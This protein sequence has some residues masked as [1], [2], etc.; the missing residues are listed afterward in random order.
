MDYNINGV[1]VAGERV[2]FWRHSLRRMRLT[3]GSPPPPVGKFSRRGA[4]VKS[5]SLIRSHC[6][7]GCET[8]V[9]TIFSSLLF[10][11]NNGG[12]DGILFLKRTWGRCFFCFEILV[13]CF[14]YI[15][16]EY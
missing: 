3:G 16:V 5:C 9:E 2:C 11:A 8:L 7:Y 13:Y 10:S 15:C 14:F 6:L 4:G 12:G 1:V